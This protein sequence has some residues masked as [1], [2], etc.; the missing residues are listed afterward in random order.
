MWWG[1]F[2]VTTT[3]PP[4]AAASQE[5]ATMRDSHSAIAHPIDTVTA[6]DPHTSF[7]PIYAAVLSHARVTLRFL[8][9][10]DRKAELTAEAIGMAWL[11]HVR[12]CRQGRDGRQF[13]TAIA[14]FALRSAL[15]G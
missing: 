1:R 8:T 7:Q 15:T 4:S 6:I 2:L 9:C 5:D 3:G 14:Q 10:A 11:W 13:P 12:L